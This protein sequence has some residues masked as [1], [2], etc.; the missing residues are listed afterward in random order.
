MTKPRSNNPFTETYHELETLAD[1]LRLHANLAG[2]EL[3]TFVDRS[4]VKV[5]DL[6]RRF[7][8]VADEAR[9][10]APEI[11]DAFVNLMTEVKKGFEDARDRMKTL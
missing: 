4:E 2:M 9:S 11:R 6:Q 8:V 5:H 1:E 10:H 7:D 3:R